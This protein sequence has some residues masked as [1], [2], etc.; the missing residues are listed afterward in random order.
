MKRISA[1]ILA[2]FVVLAGIPLF[3]QSRGSLTV[4]CN[5]TGARVYINGKISGYTNPS[6]TIMLKAG[7]YQIRVSKAGYPEFSATIT[8]GNQPVIVNAVLGG[9]STP[10]PVPQP[11]PQPVPVPAP[12]PVA[13]TVMRHNLSVHCNVNG[14]EVIINGNTAGRT[15]F[16]AQMNDGTYNLTVRAPGYSDFNTSLSIRG[17]TS[18]NAVLQPMNYVLTVSSSNVQGAEVLL[19]GQTVG[20]TPFTGSLQPGTYT[21]TVRMAGFADYNTQISMN[22]PQNV[23]VYLQPQMASWRFNGYSSQIQLYIDGQSVRNSQGQFSI[24]RHSIRIVCGSL[25]T[26]KTI[27]VE[28]G[29]TYTIQPVLD[30]EIDD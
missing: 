29:E 25:S 4:N 14:A 16:E 26:E 18:V 22:G 13:P 27:N 11:A 1:V 24:G 20:R 5:V 19:N 7:T 17:N 2:L 8:M 9:S 30:I 23:S 3:A 15:P 21:L 12:Q 10:Q 28:A 6:L